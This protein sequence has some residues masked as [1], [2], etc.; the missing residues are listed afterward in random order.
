PWPTPPI[1]R[2]SLHP[3]SLQARWEPHSS[4]WFP[5]QVTTCKGL[6]RQGPL[7]TL[8]PAEKLRRCRLAVWMT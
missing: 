6:A 3:W 7:Q 5:P 8:S 4:K 2:I 1:P